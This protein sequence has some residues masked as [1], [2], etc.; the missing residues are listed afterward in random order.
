MSHRICFL[1]MSQGTTNWGASN[2]QKCL[3]SPSGNWKS[4]IKR[5][6][7]LG[8]SKGGSSLSPR[9]ARGHCL[10][11]CLHT[12]LPTLV[13]VSK[14][15]LALRTPVQPHP[16]HLS[17][18]HLPWS[19]CQMRSHSGTVVRTLA[20]EFWKVVHNSTPNSPYPLQVPRSRKEKACDQ[21]TALEQSS[22]LLTG[23]TKITS[24]G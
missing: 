24:P 13:S 18:W 21:L 10:P 6:S 16:P 9:L 12:T 23:F 22:L 19:Y 8:P 17:W 4:E 5:S 11:V 20:C 2:Q 3:A 7:G 14:L 1:E 15:P